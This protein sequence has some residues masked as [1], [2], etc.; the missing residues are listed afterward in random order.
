MLTHPEVIALVTSAA[1]NF[2]Q[3][4]VK[5]RRAKPLPEHLL[6]SKLSRQTFQGASHFTFSQQRVTPPRKQVFYMLFT[7]PSFLVAVS[8]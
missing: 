4:D 7:T 1:S 8:Q 2:H 6:M 3:I 5:T